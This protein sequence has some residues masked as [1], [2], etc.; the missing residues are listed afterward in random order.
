MDTDQVLKKHAIIFQAGEVIYRE[1]EKA[2][3]FCF[4]ISGTVH[5]TA[6][7]PGDGDISISFHMP[8]EVF[9]VSEVFG[10][11]QYHSTAIANTKTLV[12]IFNADMV[13]LAWKNHPELMRRIAYLNGALATRL[14]DR[15]VEAQVR[16]KGDVE[17]LMEEAEEMKRRLEEQVGKEA[18]NGAIAEL[19]LELDGYL[20]EEGDK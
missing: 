20:A 11:G 8:G 9:G 16:A 7:V 2:V 12:V 3:K 1:G 15:L 17:M 18:A 19:L 13:D 4:I 14:I 6:R 10:E 5:V